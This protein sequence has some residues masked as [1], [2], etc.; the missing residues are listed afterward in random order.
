MG[1][2]S[3]TGFSVKETS[4][5]LSFMMVLD[6]TLPIQGHCLLHFLMS[7]CYLIYMLNQFPF[8]LA[9]CT[10]RS[11][12]SHVYA[13]G[14]FMTRREDL[15]VVEASTTVDEA[16]ELLVS[17]RITGLPVVDDMGRLVGVVS[18]YDLLALDSISGNRSR[19][20]ETGLFPEAGRTWKAFKEI[21]KLLLKTH[22]KTVGE[23]MTPS[24][25]VVRESTNLEDA[26]RVLLDTKFRRLPVVDD[27]GKL[28]GLLTRGNVVRAAL[29]IKQAADK[30]SAGGI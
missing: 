24:P 15:V 20:T 17:H 7:S 26:A 10:P 2:F 27:A 29:T 8:S 16:L 14:D 18:D 9:L 13:V 19:E 3:P 1:S 28:V 6:L 22:G 4:L 23:V 5:K 21:Q 12:R 11:T 25:L 30:N